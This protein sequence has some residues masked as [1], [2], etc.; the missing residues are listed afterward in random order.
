MG[1]IGESKEE[2]EGRQDK[3]GIQEK[4]AKIKGHL[5]CSMETSYSRNFHTHVR[6]CE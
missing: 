3:G 2:G 5:K 6:I 1:I 4:T